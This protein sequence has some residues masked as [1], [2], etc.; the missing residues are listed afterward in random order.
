MLN[1]FLCMIDICVM[2]VCVLHFAHLCCICVAVCGLGVDEFIFGSCSQV[3]ALFVVVWHKFVCSLGWWMC[4]ALVGWLSSMKL[5]F[6]D[7][8]THLMFFTCFFIVLQQR[9]CVLV[10]FVWNKKLI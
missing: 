5:I 8:S 10:G 3:C 2:V 7:F 6:R 4:V 9:G 1:A